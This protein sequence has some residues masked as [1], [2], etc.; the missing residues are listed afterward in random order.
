MLNWQM[1]RRKRNCKNSENN[2]FVQVL[3]CTKRKYF[4]II[5][6]NKKCFLSRVDGVKGR[7]VCLVVEYGLDPQPG[8]YLRKG[9]RCAVV[10]QLWAWLF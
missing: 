3:K 4:N 10:K 8:N 2:V 9:F 5:K 6:K 7:G 1:Q